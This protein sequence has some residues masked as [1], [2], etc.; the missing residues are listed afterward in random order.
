MPIDQTKKENLRQFVREAKMESA[1]S[2]NNFLTKINMKL[3][4]SKDGEVVK[5]EEVKDNGNN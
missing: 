2:Y 3:A 1:D 4:H 5:T